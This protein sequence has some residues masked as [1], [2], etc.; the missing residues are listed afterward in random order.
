MNRKQLITLL[1]A[2]IVIGGLG[3]HFAN[4]QK[5][6]YRTSDVQAGQKLLRTFPINDVAQI[7]IK[8][9][10]SELNLVK[11]DDAWKVK[12]RYEYPANFSE[13]S[14][15]V[16]K[17][18]DIKTVQS[19]AVGASQLGRL[20][21]AAPGSA[22]TN[23]GTLLQFKDKAGK[24][25]QSV[26]LGK[27]YGKK[28]Q[29]SQFG[30]GGDYP[31]GRYVMTESNP[32][33]VWLV[34]DP[35]SNV[36]PK[37]ESWLNK[38]FFKIDRIRSVSVTSTNATNSWKLARETESGD[39]KLV[40]AKPEEQTDTGKAS[41]AAHVLSSP[42]F[43]DIAS[44]QAKP[45]DTGLD[46]PIT[47]K[48]ETFDDFS[49]DIKIGKTAQDDNHYFAVTV[50]AKLAKERTPGKD[51]KPED[52][53]KL[54]KEFKEKAKKLEDKLKQ[55]KAYEKWVYLVPK[56]SFDALLKDRKDLIAE[57]KEEKKPE[58]AG[59]DAKPSIP[60]LDGIIPG[61][62][63]KIIPSAPPATPPPDKK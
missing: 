1:L 37:P 54:D 30:G 26:T 4:K 17:F 13:L 23:S 39:M 18:A 56:W 24:P 42:S 12:E 59:A 8:D 14:E 15:L 58:T 43:N 36:E 32:P 35:L 62:D 48:I 29:A 28:S 7:T 57:K 5:D 41:G 16:R 34:S 10:K 44:P 25:I 40:D 22:G 63:S 61:L 20:E 51:E 19:V 46:H 45:E 55:E 11:Q 9:S 27:K 2:G 52:K 6:S 50:D 38:D 47:A 21:L 33:K 53:D 60:G 3:W 49:Y 31:A